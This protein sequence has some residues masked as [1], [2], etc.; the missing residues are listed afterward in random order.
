MKFHVEFAYAPG[1]REKLLRVLQGGGLSA[2]GPLTID[3]A[4][5]AIQTGS[6]YAVI[7]TKDAKAFYQLCSA[8]SDF[9]QVK[10]TP[11]LAAS[12]V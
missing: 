7:D 5:V 3:G 6:G 2:A 8:W 4:W 10:V 9:G 1:D 11:I 12:D